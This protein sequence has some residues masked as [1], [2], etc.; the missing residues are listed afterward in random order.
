[1]NAPIG[2]FHKAQML[3]FVSWLEIPQSYFPLSHK[4]FYL[5]VYVFQNFQEP[6][7]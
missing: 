7:N 1:M 3:C 5:D 4:F 2:L 6:K